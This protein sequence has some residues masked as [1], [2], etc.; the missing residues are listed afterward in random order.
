METKSGDMGRAEGNTACAATP[1]PKAWRWLEN[2]GHWLDAG[3]L[4]VAA[5]LRLLAL[6]IKPAHFDE[7]VNGFFVDDMTQHG[8]YRYDPHNFH[9]PLHFY[10]LFAM[11]TLFGRDIAVLRLPLALASLACVAVMLFGF[12][13]LC[14]AAVARWAALAMA[15][16]PGFV[17]YGRYAI[18]ETWLVL[19]SMLFVLGL[20]EWW[21]TGAR[22]AMQVAIGGFAG[23]LLTKE[24]WIIQ[25]IAMVLAVPV[26]RGIE[27]F[28]RSGRFEKAAPAHSR[29][30]VA[31]AAAVAALA[32]VFFYSGG[33][34]YPQGIFGLLATYAPWMKTGLGGESGHDKPPSYWFELLERYEWPLLLGVLAAPCVLWPGVSRWWRW[35]AVSSGGMLAGYAIISYKT[36]WC[37][38]AWG[39]PFF[40]L[41]GA[42]IERLREKLDG[43]VAALAGG[44]F[45]LVSLL[46]AQELNFRRF[47]DESE[48]YAYVQTTLE[49][50]RLLDPLEWQ[51]ERNPASIFRRGHVIQEEQHP[52]I[53]LLGDRPEITWGD[54]NATP[55]PMDAEW[56]LIDESA[57]DRIEA[58]LTEPYFREPMQ[59]RGMAADR[60][61]LYLRAGSFFEY[62]PGRA[63][64]FHPARSEIQRRMELRQ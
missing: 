20:S 58:E 26:L 5:L 45:C 30:D 12:R 31:R 52:L 54:E 10:V 53:W 35:L 15:V 41:F 37:L 23:M 19:F 7:G 2:P 51:A 33:L 25:G 48:P 40:L 34:L 63:P 3:I 59:L 22:L 44:A 42:G 11:Q 46:R 13:R 1:I 39:W 18:H 43:P 14:S 4:L 29:E 60:S 28:S 27:Y 21:R 61:L 47:A 17:F 56:L 64:E 32:G 57:I 49:V 55:E 9:G 24:T 8:A 38:I 16:S 50:R 62:F 6:D 36:P